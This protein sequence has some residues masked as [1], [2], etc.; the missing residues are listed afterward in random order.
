MITVGSKKRKFS[1]ASIIFLV[2]VV[3]YSYQL[4][5]LSY[6]FPSE[7]MLPTIKINQELSLERAG[8]C[9]ECS[10]PVRRGE[11]WM[12]LDPNDKSKRF[13]KR[14]VGLAGDSIQISR[15]IL[16][17][18]GKV[19]TEKSVE[20]DVILQGHISKD[21]LTPDKFTIFYES[22]DTSV[23]SVAVQ[24]NHTGIDYKGVVPAGHVFVLGDNRDNS[25]DSRI[26]GHIPLTKLIARVR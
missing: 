16:R 1:L 3:I 22:I 15:G 20:K 17:I 9:L 7:S 6:K 4:D 5:Q 14:V 11:I 24:Q 10:S 13:V 8:A 23:Y 2:G 25:L 26:V 12:Y 19:V 21:P 18:N